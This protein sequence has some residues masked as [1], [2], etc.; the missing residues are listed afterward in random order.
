MIPYISAPFSNIS[1]S[2]TSGSNMIAFGV[3]NRTPFTTPYL[4]SV[5][6]I[7]YLFISI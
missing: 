7:E 6:Y 3:T 4:C 1:L 2:D 5:I